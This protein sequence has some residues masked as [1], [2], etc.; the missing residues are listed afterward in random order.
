MR[1]L[2]SEALMFKLIIIFIYCSSFLK[3]FVSVAEVF[4][5]AVVT[6]ETALRSGDSA[7]EGQSVLQTP[8]C[9]RETDM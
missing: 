9:S 7:A 1:K 5:D 8:A 4:G 6:V 2:S 3:L